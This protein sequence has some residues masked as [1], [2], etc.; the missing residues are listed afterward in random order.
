LLE[1]AVLHWGV[2]S[3]E[4]GSWAAP[5]QGWQ[6]DPGDSINAGDARSLRNAFIVCLT[7]SLLMP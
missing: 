1:G 5:P 2:A 3:R 7:A 4:G 6:S